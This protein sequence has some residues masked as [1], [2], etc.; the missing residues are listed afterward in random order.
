M[1]SYSDFI[2]TELAE[3]LSAATAE[4]RAIKNELA[5][6]DDV[7]LQD[8][9]VAAIAN[10][11]QQRD[12]Y[13]TVMGG[14]MA[15]HLAAEMAASIKLLALVKRSAY[16]LAELPDKEQSPTIKAHRAKLVEAIKRHDPE[17]YGGAK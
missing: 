7:P 8:G 17:Y 12:D 16:L 13:R 5:C 2:S 15:R 3:G 14:D 9:A 6:C 1:S 11:R 10:L 4:L